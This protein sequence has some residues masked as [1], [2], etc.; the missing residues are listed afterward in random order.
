VKNQS[1]T[2]TSAQCWPP[3]RAGLTMKH[4]PNG[5]GL[6]ER[7]FFWMKEHDS[8]RQE[9]V[10]NIARFESSQYLRQFRTACAQEQTEQPNGF[11]TPSEVL[12]PGSRRSNPPFKSQVK[13]TV[14][15]PSRWTHPVRYPLLVQSIHPNPG[16]RYPCSV[17]TQSY[18]KRKGK[19]PNPPT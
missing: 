12:L 19:E 16:H 14:V 9:V 2:T 11:T 15:D 10:N 5:L 13:Q 17:Y 7:V 3:S 1:Q 8:E 6:N 4:S 18:C